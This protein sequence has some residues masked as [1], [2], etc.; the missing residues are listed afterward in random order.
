MNRVAMM[1]AVLASLSSGVLM[2]ADPLLS[3]RG[4]PGS[5]YQEWRFDADNNPAVAEVVSNAPGTGQAAIASGAFSMGWQSQMPALGD[6]TTLLVDRHGT[7]EALVVDDREAVAQVDQQIQ[8][9]R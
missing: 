6:V 4:Q 1:L 9:T 2:A 3:W 7:R 8:P 5:T